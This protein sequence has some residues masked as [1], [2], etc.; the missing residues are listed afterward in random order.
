M[1]DEAQMVPIHPDEWDG[2]VD[3][4]RTSCWMNVLTFEPQ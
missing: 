2:L 3:G 1:I 4:S